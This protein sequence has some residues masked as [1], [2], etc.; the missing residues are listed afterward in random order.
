MR[1][2]IIIVCMLVGLIAIVTPLSAVSSIASTMGTTFYIDYINGN[3]DNIGTSVDSAW[4]TLKKV[5]DSTFAPGDKI[6]FKSG[7]AWSGQLSPK[8]SGSYGSPIVIDM[9][10]GK[11]KPIINGGG[12]EGGTVYLINQQY[13]EIKNLEITNDN[14]FLLEAKTSERKGVYIEANNGTINNHIY[15]KSCY[16]HDVDGNADG[17]KSSGGIILE[18]TN[19]VS[20]TSFNDILIEDNTISKVDRTGI[21]PSRVNGTAVN[22]NVVVRGNTLNDI[23]GDGIIIRDCISAICEYNVVSNAANRSTTVNVGIWPWGSNDTKI[24]YNESYLTHGVSDGQGFDSDFKCDGTI[25][26]YNYSHNNEGGFCLVCSQGTGENQKNTNI[27]IRYNISQNDGTRSILLSGAGTINTQIYNNTI[28]SAFSAK[29]VI[30]TAQFG[31]DTGETFICNN[32]FYMQHP[33]ASFD[34][35]SNF[36]YENNAYFGADAAVTDTHKIT[37]NPK[38]V[39]VGSGGIGRNTVDG[40]R[41]KAGSPCI[42][43]GIAITDNGGKDYWGNTL[44]NGNPDIGAYEYPTGPTTTPRPSPMATPTPISVSKPTAPKVNAVTHNDKTLRGQAQYGTVVKVQAKGKTLATAT[45]KTNKT[46]SA[47]LTKQK[48]GTKIS[49]T[50]IDKSGHKSKATVVVVK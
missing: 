43:A 49:V 6:L 45:T 48:A 20:G 37:S 41:L 39:K 10:G 23:G 29:Y 16:V 42:G 9:Y 12:I 11:Y 5:N 36:H 44:Y 35:P 13:W 17:D 30:R 27:I 24:Q 34:T 25:I 28:Y 47:T 38:L 8:G 1:K 2:A 32:I 14:N 7:C 18:G 15:I 19:G 3:D 21:K 40:Y 31:G 4:K 22:T 33:Y 50:A 26:Q 46:F